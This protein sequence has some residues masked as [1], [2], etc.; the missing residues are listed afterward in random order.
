MKLLTLN[1]HSWQEE[2]QIEKINILHTIQEKSYDMIGLQEVNQLIVEE[3]IYIN[4]KSSNFAYILLKELEKIGVTEYTLV[5]G[6][7]NEI[8]NIYEKGLAILINR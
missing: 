5:L 3:Y 8:K 1:C 7:L 2:N 4:V 6:L